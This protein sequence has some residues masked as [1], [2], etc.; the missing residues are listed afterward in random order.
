M[1]WNQTE[2]IEFAT[3]RKAKLAV[4][5]W[6]DW[7]DAYM[8]STMHNLSPT[9]ILKQPEGEHEKKPTPCPATTGDYNKWMGGGKIMADHWSGGRRC[10]GDWSTL[11][12]A[13]HGLLFTPTTPTLRSYVSQKQLRLKSAKELVLP[14]LD[15]RSSSHCPRC[16]HTCNIR[17]EEL[18]YMQ[19]T[20]TSYT[21]VPDVADVWFAVKKS[22]WL[23]GQK[24]AQRNKLIARH[25][26]L[27]WF[28]AWS[29]T[30]PTPLSSPA[31]DLLLYW[32][33]LLTSLL[34]KVLYLKLSHIMCGGCG[35]SGWSKLEGC[36]VG[37]AGM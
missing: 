15:L 24:G 6:Q 11:L 5:W 33:A 18:L 14:L 29:D 13:I 19:V 36:E 8:V 27:F 22:L 2:N 12:S 31:S 37:V 28:C 20:S 4:A 10:S 3:C 9:T 7:R 1:P 34:P 32:C 17:G 35:W 25:V 26:P 30:I 23:L 21:K 16:L